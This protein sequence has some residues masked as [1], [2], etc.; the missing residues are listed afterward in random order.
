MRG[1]KRSA[2]LGDEA[3]ENNNGTEEEYVVNVQVEC[4]YDDGLWY[5]G[6]IR[7]FRRDKAVIH[8]EDG[9][10][11]TMKLPDPDCRL[12]GRRRERKQVQRLGYDEL[13]GVDGQAEDLAVMGY[14]VG[15]QVKCKFEEGW[16]QGSITEF[17]GVKAVIDFEDGDRQRIKLPDP[18]VKLV[19]GGGA[20]KDREGGVQSSRKGKP[21]NQKEEEEEEDEDE[22]EEEEEEEDEDLDAYVAGAEVEA[23]FDDGKWYKGVITKFQSNKAVIDFEDGDR[24]RIELPDP[25]VRL[26]NRTKAGKPGKQAKKVAP[27]AAAK[28]DAQSGRSKSAEQYS[29]GTEVEVM[30]D[31]KQWYRGLIAD[32]SRGNKAVIDFEDGDRLRIELPDPDVR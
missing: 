1:G 9:D 29:I 32:F 10:V 28:P 22:E 4:K 30:F 14:V 23:K 13:G 11:L 31:D 21:S 17:H 19:S 2:S 20:P 12:A 26:L 24:D 3:A 16:F 25:D 7:E 18:D 8:F 15:C 6:T 5:R 27:A